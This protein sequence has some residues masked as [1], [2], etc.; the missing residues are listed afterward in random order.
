[1]A[2][3]SSDRSCRRRRAPL[4]WDR[5]FLIGGGGLSNFS[6]VGGGSPISFFPSVDPGF[7]PPSGADPSVMGGDRCRLRWSAF[8]RNRRIDHIT[9]TSSLGSTQKKNSIQLQFAIGRDHR[10]AAR[11]ECRPHHASL[12]DLPR[13]LAR[14]LPLFRKSNTRFAGIL[15]A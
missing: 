5:A 4:C 3:I 2:S 14:L 6:P 8:V 15:L 10:P 13:R 7:P 12:A 9:S 11:A 1:M